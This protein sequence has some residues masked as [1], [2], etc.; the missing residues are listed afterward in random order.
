MASYEFLVAI[1]S[2]LSGG[3]AAVSALFAKAAVNKSQEALEQALSQK[4]TETWSEI[5]ALSAKATALFKFIDR[6]SVDLKHAYDDLAV[7]QGQTLGKGRH[8]HFVDRVK[9]E[10]DEAREQAENCKRSAATFTDPASLDYEAA[11]DAKARLE[12]NVIY[13]THTLDILRTE[14]ATIDRQNDHYR[15]QIAKPNP[16][17][18]AHGSSS[19]LK[20]R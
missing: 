5:Q 2:I 12:S 14:L 20:S 13:L 18:P 4:K 1:G 7:F 16:P 11:S 17:T 19:T 8:Q 15:A 6:V 3:G 9:N 10:L